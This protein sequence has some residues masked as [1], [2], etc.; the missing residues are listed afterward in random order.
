MSL[1]FPLTCD[2]EASN[3]PRNYGIEEQ[4]D[5]GDAK[6]PQ[7][8]PAEDHPHAFDRLLLKVGK[9]FAKFNHLGFELGLADF[10]LLFLLTSFK[11]FVRRPHN[12]SFLR[13][14]KLRNRYRREYPQRARNPYCGG[15]N[16]AS[17]ATLS[18]RR[19]RRGSYA[20]KPGQNEI[21]EEGATAHPGNAL[22]VI[23]QELNL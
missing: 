6:N 9:K 7:R 17:L 11:S 4:K 23:R 19:A 8:E 5:D 12:G 10:F 22:V 21:D 16:P 2:A 20:K 3:N 14:L 13:D 15:D 18:G 1:G